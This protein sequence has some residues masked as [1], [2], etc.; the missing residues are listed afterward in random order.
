MGLQGQRTAEWFDRAKRTLVNGV[1]SG[2]RYW[3][4][5]DTLIIE[6]GEGPY[7]YDMDGTRYIDYQM[8]FGPVILGH[9]HPV[10]AEAVAE[11]AAAGTT[12]AMT[13]AREVAAAEKVC[14]AIPWAEALRFTNT[15]T[16]A[17][18]HALRLARAW[19]GREVFLKFE[20]C[21]H[22]AH[23]YVLFSTAGAPVGH[24]GS[25]RSPVPWQTSSGI[26]SPIRS[27]V[28][29]APF[30][31]LDAIERLF[32]NEGHSIAAMLI[33]P[34]LGNCFGIMPEPGY[35][36]GLRR[37]CDE[38]GTVMIFDEVKTGFRMALGGAAEVFGV[39]PDMGTFAKSLGNGFPVAAIAGRRDIMEAWAAGGITQAG[40]YSGNGIAAAAAAAT[41]DVLATGEPYAQI[42][43]I[44][45]A[46]M[47]G[48]DKICGNRG[49]DAHVLGH[50][51]MIGLFF[52]DEAPTDFRHT[53]HHDADL[54]ERV[55]REMIVRGVMPVDDGLEP[56]FTSAA[57]SDE[58][59][60]TTLTAFE[61]ALAAS[62]G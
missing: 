26:P 18:M 50:P 40:T 58:D 8:G 37:I 23:D 28:R 31:D 52:G 33:E 61:E 62:L 42:E 16:E 7:V 22:G 51:S 10:V 29:T 13:T 34:M 46:L 17:T 25:R 44:G 32:R 49:V 43:R 14:D 55:V 41:V 1:S 19:T 5:E 38:Y 45:R 53:A 20:G 2:F 47:D 4:D 60:A 15:G 54:Y 24:L 36:E 12:F 9:G 11:A 59:V 3:G 39:T 27:L 57:H 6:R 30:N 35:L 21:Y 48:L 56:W